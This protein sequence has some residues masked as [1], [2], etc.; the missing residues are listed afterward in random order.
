[1]EIG[2]KLRT[3]KVQLGAGSAQDADS[4]EDKTCGFSKKSKFPVKTAK[5]CSAAEPP[6]GTKIFTSSAYCIGQQDNCGILN[7]VRTFFNA[8]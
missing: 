7:L 6:F 1:M 4:A 3:T 8:Y 5:Q 2:L